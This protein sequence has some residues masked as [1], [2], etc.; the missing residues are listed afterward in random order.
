[1]KYDIKVV[2]KGEIAAVGAVVGIIVCCCVCACSFLAYKK[3]C[4]ADE[5]KTPVEEIQPEEVEMDA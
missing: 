5:S 2:T 3:M 1:M 4:G